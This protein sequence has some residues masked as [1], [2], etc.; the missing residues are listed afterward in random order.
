MLNQFFPIIIEKDHATKNRFRVISEFM[1]HG[2]G[3]NM[4]MQPFVSHVKNTEK[5]TL[6]P[7]MVITIE[8][9]LVEGSPR[10]GVWDDGWTA[11]TI[12]SG[13]YFLCIFDFNLNTLRH[14]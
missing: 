9:I 12:D 14:A 7:G 3:R 13:R 6:K 8:P 10:I 11:Y 5:F 4:H 2:V 1:G